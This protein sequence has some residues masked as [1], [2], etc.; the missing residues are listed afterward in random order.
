MSQYADQYGP[1]VGNVDPRAVMRIY[2]LL[3]IQLPM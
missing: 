1:R 2:E 3:Q